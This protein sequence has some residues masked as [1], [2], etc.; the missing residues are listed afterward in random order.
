LGQGRVFVAAVIIAAILT[1]CS[2]LPLDLTADEW[3]RLTPAQQSLALEKQAE[4]DALGNTLAAR[5][6]QNAALTALSEST[7][8]VRVEQRRKRGRLGDS[9]QCALDNASAAF[10]IGGQGTPWSAATAK[11]F[12]I[13]RGESQE[14]TVHAH[15]AEAVVSL[16]ADYAES[17]LILRLCA[18]PPAGPGVPAPV[19]HCAT[20][21]APFQAFRDGVERAVSVPDLLDGTL[22]CA[23]APGPPVQILDVGDGLEQREKFS[24]DLSLKIYILIILKINLRVKVHLVWNNV[25]YGVSSKAPRVVGDSLMM[26]AQS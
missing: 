23:F 15:G 14:V 17:G 2:A 20:V 18:V 26:I 11:G 6:Q 5:A 25:T 19:S 21:A 13:V 10:A 16:Y 1:A 12:S 22:S 3:D 4:S 9:L 7:R 24:D 8:A